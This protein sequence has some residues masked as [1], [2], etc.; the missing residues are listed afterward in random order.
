MQRKIFK[1]DIVLWFI[2]LFLCFVSILVIY[3]SAA[4]VGNHFFLFN[5]FVQAAFVAGSIG[6]MMFLSWKCNPSWIISRSRAILIFFIFISALV[7]IPGIG[8]ERN[9]AR[10]WLYIPFTPITWCPF[11]FLR[12]FIMVD[13]VDQLNRRADVISRIKIFPDFWRLSRKSRAVSK[14]IFLHVTIP[15]FLPAIIAIFIV[16]INNVSTAA[17]MTLMVFVILWFGNV[18]KR[19]IFKLFVV[20]LFFGGLISGVMMAYGIGRGSTMKGRFV[21]FFEGQK[22]EKV[23][24][25]PAKVE[26]DSGFQSSI[27][28]QK[29]YSSLDKSQYQKELAK[30]SVASGGLFGKGPGHSTLRN[31]LPHAYDDC[32]YAFIIEE[33]GLV[34]GLVI[35]VVYLALLIRGG[36]ISKRSKYYSFSVLAVALVV[37]IFV[38]AMLNMLVSVGV[39]VTGQ[40]LPLISKGGS[41]MFANAVALGILLGISA[42]QP[43]DTSKVEVVQ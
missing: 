23:E 9:D 11:D 25:V 30:V 18:H 22:T 1:G 32:V 20:V 2:I 15:I 29:R 38:T 6:I 19:E 27:S 26:N 41:A 34:G 13:L 42:F 8:V 28:V 36:T 7:L 5:A 21:S 33:Y 39:F 3:S 24:T 4:G 40:T 10:R 43:R 16:F 12:V 31:Q 17:V 35:L 14:D 37:H